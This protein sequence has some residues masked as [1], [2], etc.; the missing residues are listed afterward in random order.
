M[1]N[2]FKYLVIFALLLGVGLTHVDAASCPASIKKDLSKLANYVKIDYEVEDNSTYKKL[3][4]GDD[5]TEYKIPNYTFSFSIYNIAPELFI[6]L[7]D[8]SNGMSMNITNDMTTDGTYTFRS[9]DFGS[10]HNYVLTVKSANEE[11][12][13]AR[14]RTIKQ[15][16]PRY[17]AYSEFAYCKNS[18]SYYC[19]RFVGT[20]LN[21]KD[22]D[23]FYQK[24]KPNNKSDKEQQEEGSLIQVVKQ[25]WKLYLG[26]FVGLIVAFALFTIFMRW[27]NK[28]KEV[29]L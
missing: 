15:T 8:K 23:E 4:V 25:N 27:W 2:C 11:C 12:Y 7:E 16:Q 28:R 6:T 3:K 20:E 26:I 9:N 10:I 22:T 5:E 19:Q 1:K 29:T 17:N 13:G 24:I 21:L 18:S 14:F